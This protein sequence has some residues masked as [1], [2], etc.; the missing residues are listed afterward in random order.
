ML[1]IS[2]DEDRAGA[3]VARLPPAAFVSGLLR[4]QLVN[5]AAKPRCRREVNQSIP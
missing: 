1:R 5:N 4:Q 3:L 2:G